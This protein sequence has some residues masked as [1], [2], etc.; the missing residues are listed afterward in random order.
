MVD[1]RRRVLLLMAAAASLPSDAGAAGRPGDLDSVRIIVGF[2]PGGPLDIMARL[3]APVLSTRLGRAFAVE[4]HVGASGNLATALVARSPADGRTLLL[5]GP[6][7]AINTTLYA[8]RLD[9]DFGRDITPIAGVARVP[10]VVE[11][12]PSVRARS[13]AELIAFARANP[14][15]LRIGNAGVGTPQHIAIAQFRMMTGADIELV[16][17][18][19]SAA[20][21]ADLLAGRVQ[22][23][24]DP[25]PSSLPH[26]AAGRLVPLAV[27]SR[28]RS[29]ALPGVPVL[30]DSLPGYE[31]GSWFGIGAPR[32]V[33]SAIVTMLNDA[34]NGGLAEMAA[35]LAA[36]AAVA[37]PG[38]PA[39][40]A[41]FIGTET[42]RYRRVI[43]AARIR[44]D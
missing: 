21:L 36:L 42:D 13:A 2:P 25:L 26:I 41:A 34:I 28:E 17:Y 31:A 38:T 15:K 35:R 5:C 24:F 10:L 32:G 1:P 30:A 23:M 9:F 37:M 19:G 12:H 7:N 4:N 3:V 6:V 14:G 43:E 8:G 40:F 44:L 16:A 29:A 18:P 11:V 39:S 20:V 22:A 33:S 27:T